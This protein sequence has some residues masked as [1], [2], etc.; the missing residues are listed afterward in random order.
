MVFDRV[1]EGIPDNTGKHKVA[2]RYEPPPYLPADCHCLPVSCGLEF[3]EGIGFPIIRHASRCTALAICGWSREEPSMDL[4]RFSQEATVSFRAGL[5]SRYQ[6]AFKHNTRQQA[7]NAGIG[8]FH[9]VHSR[10]G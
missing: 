9:G 2:E 4:R 7:I 6:L 5:V 1:I 10:D 3:S 8:Q